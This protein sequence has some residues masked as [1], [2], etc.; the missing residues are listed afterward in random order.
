M[1]PWQGTF[2]KTWNL[3]VHFWCMQ[4][5]YRPLRARGYS[6]NV[7]LVVI[8]FISAIF[9]EL[10]VSVAFSTVSF[11]AFLGMLVQV[12]RR[13]SAP[14]TGACPPWPGSIPRLPS[15]SSYRLPP[16]AGR[17]VAAR[18]VVAVLVSEPLRGKQ[19]GNVFFWVTIMLG[20]PLIVLFYFV[21]YVGQH[22]APIAAAA[23][24][25]AAVHA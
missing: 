20:Q 14:E 12:R 3:G 22:A 1:R 18:Q 21:D 10:I 9:H 25:S 7:A 23:A 13:R 11:F 5:V 17:V 16:R 8:F 4:H 6:R 24:A 2:W 15:R 19:V